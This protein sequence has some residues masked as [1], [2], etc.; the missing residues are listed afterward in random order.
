MAIQV[1]ISFGE[2]Y[3]TENEQGKVVGR[4]LY[5]YRMSLQ[6]FVNVRF[7]FIVRACTGFCLIYCIRFETVVGSLQ[8]QT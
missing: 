1:V 2:G 7:G 4:S 6:F 3:M 5:L 8:A